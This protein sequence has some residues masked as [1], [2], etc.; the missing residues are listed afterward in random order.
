ML[1]SSK[2]ERYEARKAKIIKGRKTH[3]AAKR[4]RA[5]VFSIALLRD[6]PGFALE[7]DRILLD[8]VSRALTTELFFRFLFII[9]GLF[10]SRCHGEECV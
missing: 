7:T 2:N 1:L 10:D 5:F 8:L 4:I 9:G 6:D 3:A